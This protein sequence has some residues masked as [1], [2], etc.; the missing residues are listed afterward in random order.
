MRR[1][2]NAIGAL[3]HAGRF[4]TLLTGVPILSAASL[5]SWAT[6]AAPQLR[7]GPTRQ[8]AELLSLPWKRRYGNSAARIRIR[9]R[10]A[11]IAQTVICRRHH[12]VPR[13]HLATHSGPCVC[14]FIDRHCLLGNCAALAE[15]GW[16]PENSVRSRKEPLAM[17]RLCCFLV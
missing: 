16:F 17:G 4:S 3:A 8:V 1:E 2:A 15:R 6:T 7:G 13:N 11:S 5:P 10:S 9:P 14:L 12:G